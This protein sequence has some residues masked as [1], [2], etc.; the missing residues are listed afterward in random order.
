MSGIVYVAHRVDMAHGAVVSHLAHNL[1][2]HVSLSGLS[3]NT[4]KSSHCFLKQESVP[5]LLSTGW[6]KEQ[7][8]A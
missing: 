8:Q 2:M 1:W 7:I 4:N 3:L 5:S 6:F